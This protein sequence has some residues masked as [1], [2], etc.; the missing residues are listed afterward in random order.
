M[1][2]LLTLDY[3]RCQQIIKFHSASF[4]QA[5][6]R[7]KDLQRR[8]GVYA[9]YA[10]CR[11]VDDLIDEKENLPKLLAYK[12]ELDSFIKGHKVKG[13]RWRTLADTRQYYYKSEKDFVP[14]YEMIEGQEFDA[15]PVKIQTKNQLIQYCDLVASSVGKMLIPILAPNEKKDLIPFA[16]ALGRAFQ[17]TNILRDVGEDYRRN[18]IYLPEEVMQKF[19]YTIEDLANYRITP[20]FKLVWEHLANIAETYYQEAEPWIEHFPL[21][22]Q[23]P[24]RAGLVIYR[25]ILTVIRKANY[26]VMHTKHFVKDSDKIKLLSTLKGNR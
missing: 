13:F 5:F 3:F 16:N 2:L 20:A 17:I 14:F 18:R 19:G 22:A 6:S 8:R 4:Y 26:S 10:Y 23:F 21:D 24:L 9:V 1:S 12:S 25:E 15:F 11:Y 7:L